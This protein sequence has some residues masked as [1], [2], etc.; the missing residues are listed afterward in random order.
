MGLDWGELSNYGGGIRD[1]TVSLI[2]DNGCSPLPCYLR[3]PGQARDHQA[4][5]LLAL[6]IKVIGR[7]VTSNE[8]IHQ[9]LVLN[10]QQL[11]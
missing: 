2:R 10:S 3:R 1:Q 6:S 9:A 4:L 11:G 7:R 8:T 5:T